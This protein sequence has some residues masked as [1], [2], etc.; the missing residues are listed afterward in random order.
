MGE[1]AHEAGER[2]IERPAGASFGR[3]RGGRAAPAE[4]QR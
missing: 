1:E 2:E 3:E 4:D